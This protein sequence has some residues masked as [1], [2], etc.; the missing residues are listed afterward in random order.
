MYNLKTSREHPNIC[1][2]WNILIYS[3]SHAQTVCPNTAIMG[4]VNAKAVKQSS[5]ENQLR[6]ITRHRP[7]RG[8]KQTLANFAKS[9]HGKY[10]N[11]LCQKAC[12][13][14]TRKYPPGVKYK[15]DCNVRDRRDIM[16]N[17]FSTK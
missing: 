1:L 16:K 13:M 6:G 11:F 17:M 5:S 9:F 2:T 14:W 3:V 8:K 10:K 4:V 7:K 15:I 12:R